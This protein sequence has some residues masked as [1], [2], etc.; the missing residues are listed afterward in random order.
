M[1]IDPAAGEPLLIDPALSILEEPAG[2]RRVILHFWGIPGNREDT[3]L[4]AELRIRGGFIRTGI[5]L[6]QF[7]DITIEKEN[8]AAY[9]TGTTRPAA[10]SPESG[11]PDIPCDLRKGIREEAVALLYQGNDAVREG[12]IRR[13]RHQQSPLCR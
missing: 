11:C 9:R 2:S 4:V 12:D 13:C 3:M 7:S 1:R 5:D 8:M 10:G 6:F